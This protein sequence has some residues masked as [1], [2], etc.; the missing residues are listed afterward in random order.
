MLFKTIDYLLFLKSRLKGDY[1]GNEFDDLTSETM[2]AETKENSSSPSIYSPDEEMLKKGYDFDSSG[3]YAPYRYKH[4]NNPDQ[5]DIYLK[6]ERLPDKKTDFLMYSWTYLKDGEFKRLNYFRRSILPVEEEIDSK[7]KSSINKKLSHT[8]RIASLDA[9]KDSYKDFFEEL[10]MDIVHSPCL[11]V[12]KELDFD[13]PIQ[14]DDEEDFQSEEDE[15]L[16]EVRSRTDPELDDDALADAME[17]KEWIDEFGLIPYLDSLVNPFHVGNHMAVYRKHLGGVNVIRGEG[18]YFIYTKA[19]HNVGK[20]LEDKIAFLMMIPERYIFKRNQMT[21]ASF[22]RYAD[23]TIRYF[24]RMLIYFGDLGNK[25]AY[26]KVEE[27]FDAIKVLITEKEFAR[28]LTEG[29][30]SSLH[31]NTL[32]LKAESIGAVFQTVRLDFLGDEKGQ[33]G[34]R[35]IESTP[36][37]AND[38]EVLDLLFALKDKESYQNKAQDMAMEEIEKYHNYLLWIVREDIQ[39]L[40]P[41]R[42]FFKRFVKNS[43]AIF[44][45]FNQILE[46]FDA[47][48]VLTH[49][50]CL[51]HNGRLIASPKQLKIFVSELCL[52]NSL[53]P[54]ESNFLKMLMSNGNKTELKIFNEKEENDE[55][56]FSPI[57]EYENAVM[58]HLKF[59]ENLD[60]YE[61]ETFSDLEY[62]KRQSAIAKLLEMYRLGGTGINHKENV[63]FRVNDL[64]RVHSNKRAFKDVDDIG[65]ILNDL[66]SDLY[67]EKLDYSDSKGRNIYYLT[68]K[69]K[70]LINP[71]KLEKADFDDANKYLAE[72]DINYAVSEEKNAESEVKNAE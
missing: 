65:G 70:E 43:D 56:E 69:C 58:E 34:S 67:L 27:V 31:N 7:G 57:A 37:E 61:Y 71:I 68:S 30:S 20:S 4:D 3:L 8:G 21:L 28:D 2:E 18:S 42:R 6:I 25:R 63:F 19:T 26:E 64:R 72:Q 55:M 14:E 12:F 46:L 23:Q 33:I 9:K 50:D 29:N 22:S 52:E 45:D 32:E 16:E 10:V 44:R 60:D 1:M 40:I 54:V 24:E 39:V 62:S 49:G 11:E 36:M 48:C 13:F 38:D 51:E 47:F 41:Y 17:V 35:S 15:I 5:R 59:G 53:P 66:Y